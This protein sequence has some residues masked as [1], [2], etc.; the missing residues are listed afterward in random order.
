MST[1]VDDIR[2]SLELMKKQFGN[3]LPQHLNVDKFLRVTM[4]AIQ[5]NPDLLEVTR[6]SLFAE[7]MKCA[8]DGLV[9]DG[10]EAAIIPYKSSCSYQPMVKGYAKRARN[11]GEIS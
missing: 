10:S 9:P 7:L 8:Q 4:T 11:S 5:S 2:Q 6:Q 3:A 1:P